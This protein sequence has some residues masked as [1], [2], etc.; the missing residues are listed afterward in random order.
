MATPIRKKRNFKALQLSVSESSEPT[1]E[2]EP[3]LKAIRPPPTVA[4]SGPQGGKKRPPPMTL[5]APKI[6]TS[7]AEQES[8]LLTVHQLSAPL[9]SASHSARRNTLHTTLTN[10]LATLG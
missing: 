1:P 6:P 3:A 7:N 4:V 10:T 2:P 8:G 5:K 9:S